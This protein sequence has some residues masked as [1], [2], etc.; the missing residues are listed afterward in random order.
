MLRP[1]EVLNDNENVHYKQYILSVLLQVYIIFTPGD[2]GCIFQKKKN[3]N[4]S[5]RLFLSSQTS[6]QVSQIQ[7][8]HERLSLAACVRSIRQL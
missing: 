7:R 3:S 8:R 6:A 1:L 2:C 5:S 4:S